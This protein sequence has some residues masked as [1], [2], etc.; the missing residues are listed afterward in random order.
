[1]KMKLRNCVVGWV[2]LAPMA[3]AGCFALDWDFRGVAGAGGAGG[4]VASSSDSGSSSGVPLIEDC[5][6]GVDDDSDGKID[7]G[8]P[9]CGVLYECSAA[10]PTGW[11][12][13]WVIK[14]SFNDPNVTVCP[15]GQ[16]STTLFLEPAQLD[17]T[18]CS[19]CTC[20]YI[21]ATCSAPAFR[22]AY[23]DQGCMS[24]SMPAYASEV[25][26]CYNLQNLPTNGYSLGSCMLT[27]PS[28]VVTKGSAPGTPSNLLGPPK[29]GAEVRLCPGPRD[30]GGG[31]LV[32]DACM[33]QKPGTLG[34]AGRCIAQAGNAT[35]PMG[36][37]VTTY[38]A[39]E[40]GI[41]TR[42]CSNCSGDPD[43]VTCSG[44]KTT[45]Y[46]STKICQFS[47]VA[48]L[49]LVNLQEC[50]P[51]QFYPADSG[52]SAN[53]VLGTPIDGPCNPAVPTGTV[54]GIGP[55]TICC[56]D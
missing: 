38:V 40:K 44:G 54:E 48:P 15:D 22:C 46:F 47:G 43:K 7:C 1:M 55:H 11:D 52:E 49:E 21:G 26:A 23:W 25:T 37:N 10:L 32:G 18:Q 53:F 27:A 50:K 30:Q 31:C 42:V 17:K 35:C 20:S 34:Q 19:E 12:P 14:T 51:F 6:N 2:V 3:S 33:Q 5:T 28:Y 56:R 39:Y 36:W 29:F 24:W 16:A 9:D 8:D 4:A 41:D 13:F 45:I